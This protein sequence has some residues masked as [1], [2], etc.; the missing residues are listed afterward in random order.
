MPTYTADSLLLSVT[1]TA[2][3]LPLLGP[4]LG[5]TVTLQQQ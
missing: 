1:E 2:V 4:K 3:F 5:I